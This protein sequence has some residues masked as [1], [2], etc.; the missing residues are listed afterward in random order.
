MLYCQI[1]A[2][3]DVGQSAAYFLRTTDSGRLLLQAHPDLAAKIGSD[4]A[5]SQKSIACIA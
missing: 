4:G 3:V 2:G 1:S 5:E